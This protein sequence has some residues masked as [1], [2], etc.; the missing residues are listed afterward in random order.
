MIN[1]E[2][3]ENITLVSKKYNFPGFEAHYLFKIVLDEG[4]KLKKG[5]IYI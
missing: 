1:I 2:L 5:R 4:I 3:S